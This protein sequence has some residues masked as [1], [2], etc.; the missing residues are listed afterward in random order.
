MSENTIWYTRCPV[1]TAFSIALRNGWFDEEF[2][3][4]GIEVNSLLKS[5]DKSIR[6]SH[7]D[8][9]LPDSFRHGGNAPPIWA[10]SKGNDVRLI[11]LSSTEQPQLLLTLPESGIK[12]AAD[13]KGKRL[14]LPRRTR[15]SIDFWR[16]NHL[17]F[18]ATALA[19]VGLTLNDVE[20]VEIPVNRRYLDESGSPS[21]DGSLWNAAQLRGSQREE[22]AA[23][24]RGKVDVLASSGP[25]GL[26]TA[27]LLGAHV[28]HDISRQPE[29][30][31]KTS[32]S[33][34]YTFTVSGQLLKQRPQLVARLLA[35]VLE[36]AEWAK[37]H[38]DDAVR[39]TALE[40]GV[41]EEFVVQAFGDKLSQ[42][43]EVNLSDENVA[44][45]RARKDFLLKHE[46]LAADFDVDAWI[47]PA[48]L[49]EA[50]RIVKE[51]A[52]RSKPKPR[53]D[54]RAP[55]AV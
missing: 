16:S 11:G 50:Q 26:E 24:L 53:R 10:R 21:K 48:P 40:L 39:V 52:S 45:L 2:A 33:F 6:E 29:R 36:A 30:L 4:E 13:L 15:D 35:R 8:H 54:D 49:Q 41:A 44:A 18:Y 9:T 25:R 47:D 17:Q 38:H 43:L 1:P 20:L 32:N 42:Q 5:T 46:F 27:A 22:I 14:A 28:V 31:A 34:P 37:T 55:A 51:R 23:L 12:S 3:A 19:S 7:F